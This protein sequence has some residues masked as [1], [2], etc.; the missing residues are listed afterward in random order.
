LKN[1]KGNKKMKLERSPEIRSFDSPVIVETPPASSVE[2]PIR[3]ARGDMA[4][5]LESIA[6]S[7]PSIK[8]EHTTDGSIVES[9][10]EI[11]AEADVAPESLLSPEAA[12]AIAAQGRVELIGAGVT[13]NG[14][15]AYVSSGIDQAESHANDPVNATEVSGGGGKDGEGRVVS[16][17]S[18]EL[19]E[20]A[21][22][23]T[24]TEVKEPRKATAEEISAVNESLKT[25]IASETKPAIV[26]APVDV[27]VLVTEAPKV[28]EKPISGR[29]ALDTEKPKAANKEDQELLDKLTSGKISSLG[30]RVTGMRDLRKGR[31]EIIATQKSSMENVV[32]DAKSVVSS[33][34]SARIDTFMKYNALTRIGLRSEK[35]AELREKAFDAIENADV[36]NIRKRL[37]RIQ[38]RKNAWGNARSTIRTEATSAFDTARGNVVRAKTER[39]RQKDRARAVAFRPWR[40]RTTMGGSGS[41]GFRETWQDAR[42]DINTGSAKRKQDQ[43]KRIQALKKR[44]ALKVSSREK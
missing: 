40:R 38:A 36:S 32:D 6:K 39:E 17:T 24:I 35:R 25:F 5:Q 1:Q 4:D 10:S 12:E 26:E 19:P 18:G 33:A 22:A 14:S 16:A 37:M 43:E 42:R 20:P 23:S 30:T 27:P 29:R 3:I 44:Q 2:T 15:E 7:D 9:T 21:P 28:P 8:L 11:P 31:K 13:L 41:A 34:R